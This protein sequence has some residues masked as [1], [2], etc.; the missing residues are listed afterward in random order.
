MTMASEIYYRWEAKNDILFFDF[1]ASLDNNLNK[2]AVSDQEMSVAD[3]SERTPKVLGEAGSSNKSIYPMSLEPTVLTLH[4]GQYLPVGIGVRA[5]S[6][7]RYA[8]TRSDIR[9]W[10]LGASALVEILK[11]SGHDILANTERIESLK[12]FL[13]KHGFDSAF[14]ESI[15]NFPQDMLGTLEE[16]FEDNESLLKSTGVLFLYLLRFLVPITAA[17]GGIHLTAWNFE[18]PS[19]IESIIWRIACFIIMGSSFALL[20]APSWK[21]L[22]NYYTVRF[23]WYTERDNLVSLA[24]HLRT[25]AFLRVLKHM[26][27]Y[28]SAGLLLLCY[29]ASRVYLVVESFISLRHVPIGVY[30]AVPWVQN[31]PHV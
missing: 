5:R 26:L 8:L 7:H 28:G 15:P 14:D 11:S 1:Q 2:L 10:E 30:A 21:A 18:F 19:R 13:E 24:T 29:A 17:Y 27:N 4:P 31:I 23:R 20:A 6:Y 16:H 25:K 3:K 9:R 12:S 22:D